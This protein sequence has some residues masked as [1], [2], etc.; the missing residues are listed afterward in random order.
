MYDGLK[1]TQICE[2]EIMPSWDY[3]L[4]ARWTHG[5]SLR[6][7]TSSESD[8]QLTIDI[9]ELRQASF[10]PHATVESFTVPRHDGEFSFS[11]VSFHASFV[12]ESAVVILNVRDSKSLLHTKAV[13][14]LSP[15]GRFSPDGGFFACN[16]L[17]HE[18]C[19]WKN[20][21]TSYVPW[22]SLKPRLPFEGFSFSPT[23]VSVL[24]WG[25]EGIQL[26]DPD[27]RLNSPSP[28][29]THLTGIHL[30][31]HSVG[32]TRI[33]TAR[34]E[35]GV[36]TILDP[37]SGTPLRS[38]NTDMRIRDIKIFGDTI[39]VADGYKFVGW[40]LEPEGIA[41]GACISGK[42][43]V[44]ETLTIGAPME[45]VEVS[46]DCSRIAFVDKEKVSLYDVQARRILCRYLTHDSVTDIRFSPDGRQLCLITNRHAHYRNQDI[47]HHLVKLKIMEDQC[48]MTAELL[49]DGWPWVG[50]FST[51]GCH[52]GNG[53]EWVT[54]SRG[55]KLLW[56]PPN[57]RTQRWQD[58]RWNGNF[59][60]FVGAHHPE[61]IIIEFV[62]QPLLPVII[63]FQPQ[64]LLPAHVQPVH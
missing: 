51:H 29:K 30:V 32:G 13:G 36:V 17:E 54:D 50:H 9:R 1:G 55:S 24:T 31:A 35:D 52:I 60:T 23:A 53:S 34:R 27:N 22:S 10:S 39:F 42:A 48:I 33:A 2:G 57:W 16:T 38:I 49:R 40:N 47:A 56:L 58:V 37:L 7:A 18:I 26:L 8:G 28:D 62:P 21:P 43:T 15:P 46:N 45:H 12:T 44:D 61:P 41:D 3:R 5:E 59:L 19:V 25:L 64:P 11:P 63:E 20:T 4:G 14:L 6:F